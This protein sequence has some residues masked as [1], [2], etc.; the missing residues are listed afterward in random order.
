M[1]VSVSALQYSISSS[2]I[3]SMWACVCMPAGYK[4]LQNLTDMRAGDCDGK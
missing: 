4:A 2:A 3:Y 1:D